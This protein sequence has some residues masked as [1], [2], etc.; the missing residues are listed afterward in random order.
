MFDELAAATAELDLA[1]EQAAKNQPLAVRLM[2][3][4]GVGPVTSLAFE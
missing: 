3:H 2:T 4:P 1:V